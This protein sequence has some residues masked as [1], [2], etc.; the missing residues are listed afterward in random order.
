MIYTPELVEES[1]ILARYNLES[2]RQGLKVHSSAESD[3]I[4][5]TER[6]YA[7]G[8]VSQKDGGFLT[9]RGIVAAEHA[10]KLL[11]ILS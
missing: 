1:N 6:L 5:A 8:L 4:A 9:S 7:K 11:H 3:A 2:T 10:Q